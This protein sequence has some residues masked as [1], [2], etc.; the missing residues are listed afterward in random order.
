MITIFNIDSILAGEWKNTGEVA[1][2]IDAAAKQWSHLWWVSEWRMDNTWRLVKYLRKDSPIT[3]CKL[4]ISPAQAKELIEVLN[5][6]C[7]RTYL[8][9][10]F[11][12]RRKQDIFYLKEYRL[13]KYVRKRMALQNPQKPLS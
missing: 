4:S 2:N 11:S 1:V 8:K 13:R 12:W 3:V 5:L 10:S 6:K 7:E 9:S